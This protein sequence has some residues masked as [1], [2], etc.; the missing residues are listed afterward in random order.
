MNGTFKGCAS[1][2]GAPPSGTH[3]TSTNC[4]ACHP[5]YTATTVNAA[6]HVDGT[7]NYTLTTASCALCHGAPPATASHRTAGGITTCSRCHDT[8]VDASGNILTGGT[9][10]NGAVNLSASMSCATC[11]GD[12]TRIPN[13]TV[14]RGR[15]DRRSAGATSPATPPPPPAAWART[16]ST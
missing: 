12:S 2:H 5:G 3:P 9:H 16:S 13:P 7:V 6:T 1:C 8:S 15:R 4:V 11:H 14:V 10:R